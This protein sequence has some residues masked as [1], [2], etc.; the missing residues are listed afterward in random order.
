MAASAV[1]FFIVGSVMGRCFPNSIMV[2]ERKK[3]KK[4]ETKVD[5]LSSE[6]N[7]NS[8][9]TNDKLDEHRK[10]FGVVSDEMKGMKVDIEYLSSKTGKHDMEFN[11]IMNRLKG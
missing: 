2:K 3:R 8:K 7:S 5:N 4:I 11:N 10:V 6:L 9:Y 1:I